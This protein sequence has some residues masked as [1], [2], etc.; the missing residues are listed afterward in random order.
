MDFVTAF[1]KWKSVVQSDKQ[2][3]PIDYEFHQLTDILE[4]QRRA[5]FP[6]KY[7]RRIHNIK[8]RL[9]RLGVTNIEIL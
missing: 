6:K 3:A 7:R 1:N 5:P 4:K 9:K 2:Y 8:R